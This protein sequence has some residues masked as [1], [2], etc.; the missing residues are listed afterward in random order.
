MER[1]LDYDIAEIRKVYDK[2]SAVDNTYI[3]PFI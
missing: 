3:L 1:D 2:I